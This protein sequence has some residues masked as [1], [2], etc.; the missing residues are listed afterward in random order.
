ML[1]K[2]VQLITISN[3]LNTISISLFCPQVEHFNIEE[4]T[5]AYPKIKNQTVGI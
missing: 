4:E 5:L 1:Y 2:K 3:S